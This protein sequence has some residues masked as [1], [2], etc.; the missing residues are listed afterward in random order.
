M[1]QLADIGQFTQPSDPSWLTI[2]GPQVY[3]A[4]NDGQ[5]GRRLWRYDSETGTMAMV[6]DVPQDPSNLLDVNGTLYFTAFD[7]DHGYELWQSDGTA[8]GTRLVADVLPGPQSASPGTLVSLDGDLYLSAWDAAHGREPWWLP[9]T[10]GD[11]NGD[12]EIGLADFAT[13]KNHF[14]GPGA[15]REGDLTGDGVIDL[16]DF[17]ILKENFGGI[18]APQGAAT[19]F[20]GNAPRRDYD[21]I[22][23]ALAIDAVLG[24]EE[25][26][27]GR[28]S[29]RRMHQ[30]LSEFQDAF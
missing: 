27:L 13:V 23:L 3:F 10:P 4:A 8:A 28:Q 5:H 6:S 1:S 21:D 25:D 29:R 16:A 18:V 30:S 17:G 19:T 22:R 2:I 7:Q 14:D 15:R 11:T 20:T 24:E 12:R 9:A 26:N